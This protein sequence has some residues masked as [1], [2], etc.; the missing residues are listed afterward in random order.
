MDK[1][2]FLERAR[3]LIAIE[4]VEGNAE[5]LDEALEYLAALVLRES[6]L[7]LERFE[8]NGKPSFL[9]YKG[10]ARPTQ[11]T[12]LLN[13]HVDVVRGEPTQ[14]VMRHEGDKLYGRGTLD[15]KLAA[16]VMT[17]VFGE[18]A[19]DL[20]YAVGLQ[21]VSDEETNGYDGT[22]YQR[23]QGVDGKF[24]ISGEAS[25]LDITVACKGFCRVRLTAKGQAAHG[26]Y[27]WRGSNA[28]LRLIASL[29]AILRVYP[30]PGE[31]VWRTTVNVSRFDASGNA[32]NQ[33]PALA[34]A[35]LDI[36]YVAGDANFASRERVIAFFRG[37]D[38]G[39]EVDFITDVE[40][41]LDCDR[42]NPLLKELAAA[43]QEVVGKAPGFIRKHGG[44]DARFY[45]HKAVT[46][47]LSGANAHGDNEQVLYESIERYYDILGNFLLRVKDSAVVVENATLVA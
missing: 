25:D 23:E 32:V 38:E 46:F 41:P 30:V 14:F 26:A 34:S 39:M 19:R 4:S 7:T 16:L 29:E 35:D 36:R 45:A 18:L 24:V 12:V 6:G 17:M 40:P 11:F 1:A 3:K 2:L 22:K 42:D 9:A 28:I 37:I 15:M 10:E 21:I 31:E 5:A 20:P 33:V 8:R 13:G 44:A 47:G 43:V 27:L